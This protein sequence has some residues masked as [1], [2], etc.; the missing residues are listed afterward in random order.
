[1]AIL[2]NRYGAPEALVEAVR[3]DPYFAGMDVEL[4]ASS[5]G[6]PP[7]VRQL[8]REHAA[9]IE[10]DVV[11]RFWLL[12]GS[13]V[14]EI[15]A[16][17]RTRELRERRYFAEVAGGRVSAQF[18][19]YLLEAGRLTEWKL[20][21]VWSAVAGGRQEW[22][23]QLNTAAA[24]LEAN[25]LPVRELRVVALLRDWLASRARQ[26]AKAREGGKADGYP[27][28]PFVVFRVP[29]WPAEERARWI[30]ERL[31][32]HRRAALGDVADCT[33]EE[34]WERKGQPTR[35]L[36]FCAVA[37][38]CPQHAA[39]QASAPPPPLEEEKPRRRRAKR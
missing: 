38:W 19:S 24:I 23:G 33:A 17:Q 36:H 4:S 18:D 26:A 27:P 10:E 37:R 21:S 29:L 25:A 15:L 1:M 3:R 8:Q 28:A 30:G 2:T 12:L 11:D 35:C 20:T 14:H 7:R 34:R 31:E 5:I 6:T 13:M 22:V 9:E 16:R 32:L 39:W